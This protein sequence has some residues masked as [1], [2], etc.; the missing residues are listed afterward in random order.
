MRRQV[1][2]PIA[3]LSPNQVYEKVHYRFEEKTERKDLNELFD[4]LTSFKIDPTK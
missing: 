3:F 4:G 2:K 1:Y